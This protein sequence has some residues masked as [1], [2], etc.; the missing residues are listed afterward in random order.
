M[1]N[2]MI[3]LIEDATWDWDDVISECQENGEVPPDTFVEHIAD[4]LIA[5]GVTLQKWIPVSERLPTEAEDKNQR[6]VGVVNGDKGNVCFI[7]APIFV[8]YSHEEKVWWSD[9]YD[10]EGCKVLYWMPL[11]EPPKGE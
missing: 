3:E 7:D 8:R 4:H 5:N 9:E 11:P 6:L 1:R 2:K 10:I